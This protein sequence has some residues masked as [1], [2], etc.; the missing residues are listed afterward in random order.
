MKTI[1]F[2]IFLVFLVFWFFVYIP[3][4]CLATERSSSNSVFCS[5]LFSFFSYLS[6]VVGRTD[7]TECGAP[8]ASKIAGIYWRWRPAIIRPS[9]SHNRFLSRHPEGCRQ[10]SNDGGSKGGRK[11]SKH[12]SFFF[13]SFPP[14]L[15]TLPS[16]LTLVLIACFF[17]RLR[18]VWTFDPHLGIARSVAFFLNLI[19]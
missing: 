3:L 1:V 7:A 13:P 12:F 8:R 5:L 16:Y 15:F 11:C 9:I 17:V 18:P 10:G 14:Y 2:R 4:M 6:V 19:F